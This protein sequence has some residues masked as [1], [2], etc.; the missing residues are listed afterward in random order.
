[1]MSASSDESKS[2]IQMRI[3]LFGMA[4]MCIGF[5]GV[6]LSDFLPIFIILAVMSGVVGLL[7]F[8][9]CITHPANIKVHDVLGMMLGIA[10][11]TGTLN[12]LISYALDNR[13][14]LSSSSVSAYWLSRT[15]GFS[16]AA[17]GFLHIIG[18]FDSDGYLFPKLY[19]IDLQAKRFLWFVGIVTMMII[20]LIATGRLGFMASLSVVT[21]SAE[22]SPSAA[23]ALDLMTPTGALALFFG[24]KDIQRNRNRNILFIIL[25]LLLLLVQFGLGRRIFV[26]STLI[27]IMTALL[28]RRSRKLFSFRNIVILAVATLAMQIATTAFYTMRIASYSFNSM[29]VRPSISDLIPEAIGVYKNREKLHVAEQIRENVGSRTFVLEYL[30]ILSERSSKIEPTYGL[31]LARAIIVTT[32]SILYPSKYRN[33]LFQAEEELLNVHF[34]LPVWDAANSV[35][36]ASVGDFGEIG[37]FILPAVMSFM[38][39]SI[40]RLTYSFVPPAAGMLVSFYICKTLLSV[41]ED[42]SNYFSSL[43]SIVIILGISWLVFAG[44]ILQSRPLAIGNS[45]VCSGKRIS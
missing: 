45:S 28:A 15:L 20:L 6:I 30:A 22:I 13:D 21:G 1:M 29:Y 2:M 5:A 42:I 36:T 31:N 8:A 25:A 35:L 9:F 44:K 33:P 38:F 12:T 16:T 17:A 27:Y 43:R 26:I 18:R 23:I 19:S 34:R 11:G 7:A 32:P 4:E 10:Y 40:L 14:L 3:L 24:L 41:E 37:L 39:S